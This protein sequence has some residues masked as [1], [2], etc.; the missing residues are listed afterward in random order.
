MRAFPGESFAST[1]KLRKLFGCEFDVLFRETIPEFLSEFD[2]LTRTE[3]SNV[4]GSHDRNL[5]S[6]K[7]GRNLPGANA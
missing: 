3:A 7:E 1:L 4:E 2:T 5:C 6:A